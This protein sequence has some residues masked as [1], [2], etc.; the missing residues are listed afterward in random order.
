LAG[1]PGTWKGDGGK[2]WVPK[3]T[4]FGTADE[5]EEG[6]VA[7]LAMRTAAAINISTVC[8]II[9]INLPA[10]RYLG[11]NGEI[12]KFTQSTY[13]VHVRARTKQANT[14]SKLTCNTTTDA[15]QTWEGF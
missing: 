1:D 2:R 15:A 9:Y 3:Y 14:Q 6:H 12:L 8:N 11:Y 10:G 13:V 7:R 5:F 4:K